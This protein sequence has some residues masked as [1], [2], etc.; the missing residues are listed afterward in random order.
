M[1]AADV[2]RRRALAGQRER[3][4]MRSRRAVRRQRHL[5]VAGG[6][7]LARRQQ[8]RGAPHRIA[9]RVRHHRPVPL[10]EHPGVTALA[11]RRVIELLPEILERRRHRLG[12][13]DH[14]RRRL[15]HAIGQLDVVERRPV[16]GR[17]EAQHGG[18]REEQMEGARG[19]HGYWWC[20][21]QSARKGSWRTTSGRRASARDTT[22]QATPAYP[23]AMAISSVPH[24]AVRI[25]SG[26]TSR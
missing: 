9:P 23:T 17:A 14:V 12:L 4:V 5:T 21:T 2:E 11:L 16:H 6:R 19:G 3:V 18:G 24:V 25:V 13:G 10:L 26:A 20:C 7:R 8:E 22:C 15:G 1:R